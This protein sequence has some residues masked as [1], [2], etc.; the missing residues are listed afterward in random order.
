MYE[1]QHCAPYG[2][3]QPL[4]VPP[5]QWDT[6]S[7]DFIIELPESQG[8]NAIMVVVDLVAE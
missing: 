1:T 4:P 3:L 5:E 7:V 2:E 8:F 6:I